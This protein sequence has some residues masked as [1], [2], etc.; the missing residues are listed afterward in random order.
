MPAVS[1]NFSQ[2]EA[3]GVAALAGKNFV[4]MF[5]AAIQFSIVDA[6]ELSFVAIKEHQVDG[7]TVAPVPVA[8]Q[9]G[10]AAAASSK[11]LVPKC[12]A[13]VHFRPPG[14]DK[15]PVVVGGGAETVYMRVVALAAIIYKYG[16]VADVAGR[17]RTPT[18]AA[19]VNFAPADIYKLVA[20]VGG[21]ESKVEVD[22]VSVSGDSQPQARHGGGG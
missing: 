4:P 1:T 13:A 15:E 9:Q 17:K 16:G 7:P 10:S 2:H 21:Q 11:S 19:A 18:C 20:V 5:T 22:A 12:D 6:V 14:A 8:H 3:G